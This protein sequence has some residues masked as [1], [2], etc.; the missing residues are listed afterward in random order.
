MLYIITWGLTRCRQADLMTLGQGCLSV[1]LCHCHRAKLTASM[2]RGKDNTHE[3]GWARGFSDMSQAWRIGHEIPLTMTKCVL[4]VR[5][6]TRVK[7][8]P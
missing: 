7:K 8:N 1:R 5:K 2:Y 4:I 6:I 3:K